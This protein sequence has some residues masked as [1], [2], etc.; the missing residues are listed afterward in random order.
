MTHGVQSI[1]LRF[2]LPGSRHFPFLARFYCV[3]VYPVHIHHVAS[4][5]SVL[6]GSPEGEK[7]FCVPFWV[8]PAALLDVTLSTSQYKSLIA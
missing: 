8:C 3:P 6:A 7:Y 1:G 4:K 2:S 5:P